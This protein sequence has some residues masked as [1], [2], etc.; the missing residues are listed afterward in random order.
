MCIVCVFPVLAGP[1]GS[2]SGFGF[3]SSHRLSSRTSTPA[4]DSVFS[5]VGRAQKGFNRIPSDSW[6]RGYSPS[7]RLH[8]P[9]VA[10][11]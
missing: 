2:I 11:Q 8:C 3:T 7:G 1:H 5:R 4:R 10:V 9:E 6:Y